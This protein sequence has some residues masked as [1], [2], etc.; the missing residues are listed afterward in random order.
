MTRSAA[1]VPVCIAALLCAC[2]SATQ[3]GGSPRSPA[4]SP[5]V[6][7]ALAGFPL[8]PNSTTESSQ[9]WTQTVSSGTTALASQGSGTYTGHRVIVSTNASFN[10]L[11]S[12]IDG[13]DKNPPSGFASMSGQAKTAQVHSTL[14][15][16]GID[17]AAFEKTENGKRVGVFVLAIDPATLTTH[18]GAGIDLIEKYRSLPEFLRKPLDD[19]IQ[20]RY[21]FT[22]TQALDP[23][24]PIG[25]ALAAYDTV[26]TKN[27]RA[28]VLV[29]ATKE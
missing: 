10:E 25:G 14:D 8:Y 5:Q 1:A 11:Q 6:S 2:S 27:E 26:K 18:L 19:Q 16:Y 24:S 15:R 22:G 4:A 17:F 20:A 12:W 23:S 21:G 29:D 13:L 7:S 28:V 3:S 9:P